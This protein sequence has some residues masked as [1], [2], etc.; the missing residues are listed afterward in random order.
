MNHCKPYEKIMQDVLDGTVSAGHR[1]T[2]ERHLAHCRSCRNAFELLDPGL[3]LLAA[4]PVPELGPD[5][6]QKTVLMA[7]RAKST[8]LKRRRAASWC[9]ASLIV[10]FSAFFNAGWLVLIEPAVRLGLRSLFRFLVQGLVLF[11]A[12][13]KLQDA[14]ATISASLGEAAVTVV[15]DKGGPVFI[16]CLLIL[17]I[18]AFV[19]LRPGPGSSAPAFKRR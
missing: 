10:L 5:F 19:I 18:T 13:E 7:L 9:L 8:R 1:E 2:L 12:F 11:S 14:L 3:E 16:G 6:T 15:L 17:F 4:V